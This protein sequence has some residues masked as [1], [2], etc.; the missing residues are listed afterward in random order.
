MPPY[1][2]RPPAIVTVTAYA[3]KERLGITQMQYF[4]KLFWRTS[5][6]TP[7]KKISDVCLRSQDG[8]DF[9]RQG[10]HNQTHEG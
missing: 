10:V 6:N 3:P 8:R 7:T 9:F 5:V 1:F 2:K 4:L